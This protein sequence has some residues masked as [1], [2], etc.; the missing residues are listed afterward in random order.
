MARAEPPDPQANL[1]QSYENP[2]GLLGRDLRAVV[3]DLGL[4]LR[5][6]W[7]RNRQGDLSVPGFWPGPLQAWFWPLLLALLL[8]LPWIAWNRLPHGPAA[9]EPR[10]R[11]PRL[12]QPRLRQQGP[13]APGPERPVPQPL[14]AAE[15]RQTSQPLAALPGEDGSPPSPEPGATAPESGKGA[16]PATVPPEEPAA[17]LPLALDPLLQMLAEADPEQLI[18]SAHP[19]PALSLLRLTLAPAY[20][21][22]PAASRSQW[23]DRW[24]ERAQQLGYEHFE[25]VDDQQRP[26]GRKALVG[27]GMILL[28]PISRL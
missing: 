5:A 1:P 3:A 10:L 21:D 13:A 17:A 7:R 26:L 28:D 15:P 8:L 23:A 14:A 27:S 19:E 9:A 22:L 11:E 2:W 6:L 18:V 16:L 20:G 12:T 4:Q 25:L 24:C